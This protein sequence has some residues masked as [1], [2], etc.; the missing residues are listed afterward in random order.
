MSPQ[1]SEWQRSARVGPYAI[2]MALCV[3]FLIVSGPVPAHAQSAAKVIE[4]YIEA[5][6]GKD[7]I[8]KIVSTEVSGSVRA[9]DGR[10]GVFLQRTRRPDLFSVSWSLGD[11]RERAGF[12]GRSAWQDEGGSG[13]RTQYGQAASRIRGEAR[14]ANTRFL[15]SEKVSRV[16]VARHEQLNGRAVI[17]IIA[18]T[19]DGVTRTLFFDRDSHLLVKDQWQTNGIVE[20]RF[21]DD[22]RPVDQVREPHRIEWH[23]NGDTFRI[24][25]ERVIHNAP[26]DDEAFD[27]PAAPMQPSVDIAAVLSMAG[28]AEQRA[29]RA[30]MSYA[31]TQSLSVRVMDEKGG[32]TERQGSAFE[33]FHLGGQAVGRQIR[34]MDGQPLSD[35]ERRREDK[36]VTDLVK[37]YERQGA[38]TLAAR[39]G[40][41]TVSASDFMLRGLGGALVLSVPVMT[42]GWFP[43]YRRVSDFSNIRRES[44][45]RRAAIVLDFRPRAGVTPT[46]NVERQASRMAGTLWI[47][48]ASQEVIRIESHFIDDYDSIVQ[49]SAVSMEQA[50]VNDEVWLP[51]R[52][53]TNVRRS[54]TFGA[55]AQPLITV[56]F[57][58][59]KKFGV[60]TDASVTLPDAGR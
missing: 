32:V 47:D 38:A 54:L 2:A 27:P 55:L 53:E 13:V 19:P 52:L 25:V 12:N 23:R 43:A 15:V 48:E 50:R 24:A 6:G 18:V 44:M 60:E 31:Y 33:I 20:E 17:V 42:R 46:G 34:K 1:M 56:T 39:H 5:I 21:F 37:E 41:E 30:R 49:G 51:A 4:R 45:G 7:A 40:R 14:Y 22:Y 3:L 26:V 10:V 58:D 36:R 16:S 9:A 8:E 11:V 29:E 35:V 57:S 59:H 28:L